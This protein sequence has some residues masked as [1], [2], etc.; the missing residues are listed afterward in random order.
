[1]RRSPHPY[2]PNS[3]EATR[4]ALLQELGIEDVEDLYAD[5]PQ[6]VRLKRRLNLPER[7]PEIQV[8][9]RIVKML[10]ENVSCD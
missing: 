6:E 8:K 2:I 4:R 3:A 1:M 10:S 5:I 9:R 7:T